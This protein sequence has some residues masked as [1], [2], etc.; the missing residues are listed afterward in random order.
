M[1]CHDFRFASC[2]VSAVLLLASCAEM[3]KAPGAPGAVPGEAGFIQSEAHCYPAPHAQVLQRVS[4][5]FDKCF[6]SETVTYDCMYVDKEGKTTYQKCD[7]I[8]Y[9]ESLAEDISGGRRLSGKA[10]TGIML[11]ADV[12]RG[13]AQCTSQLR[14]QAANPGFA[15][16]FEVLDE[17]AKGGAVR[18]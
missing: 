5:Y 15:K 7:R 14:M 9:R 13:P 6:K 3:P 4:G 18:C 10:S 11:I 8:V 1:S 12:T 16:Q 2:C 17:V